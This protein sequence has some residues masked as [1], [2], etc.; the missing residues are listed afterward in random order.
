LSKFT[1]RIRHA[2]N[3][4]VFMNQNYQSIATSGELGPVATYRPERPRLR[5]VG[6]KTI[7]AAIYTRIANDAASIPIR[8]VKLNDNSLYQED[9]SSGLNDCLTV[10]A[11]I[12][13]GATMFKLDCIQ[14]LFDWGVIAIVPVDTTLN[15][16]ATG[17]YDVTSMRVGQV[18]Q[19]YPKY[20]YVRVYNERKGIR[21]DILLPKNMVAI[22]EN[23][24]YS[25]MNEPSSTLQR[26]IKTLT[27]LDVVDE[28]S[29]SGKL[30][31]IIQLPYSL[32][33]EMKKAEADRRRKEIEFQLKGSQLGIAYTDA[34]E[35]VIQLNRPVENNLMNRVE[36]LTKMLYGQL[37]LDDTIMNNTAEEKVMTLYYSRSIEPL[38][39]A[40]T[41]AMK[42][43]FLTKTARTQGQSVIY[44]RDPFKLVPVSELAEI[45]DKFT[46]NEIL[47][48]NEF[49]SV[50]GFRPS[51]DKKADMLLNKNIPVAAAQLPSSTPSPVPRRPRQPALAPYPPLPAITRGVTSQNGT[52]T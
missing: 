47:T 44:I 15:P 31:I 14:S 17:G 22:V 1:D 41:E 19:W 25:I 42:R 48:S 8:H 27:L 11:N 45:A 6:D 49:R 28:Q 18:M 33:N 4:F 52:N 26:L 43:T 37:G 46:R 21:E 13:Q 50:V 12:D 9:M 10:S 16:L 2:W 29:A 5:Y 7:I 36:Y 39:T 3:A 35:R 30:D 51:K 32:K 34:T 38:L 40:I 23:P 24:F 20:V